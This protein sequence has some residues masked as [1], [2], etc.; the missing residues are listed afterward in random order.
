M[1]IEKLKFNS[2]GKTLDGTSYCSEVETIGENIL[3]D[4]EEEATLIYPG[5]GKWAS[6]RSSAYKIVDD[7]LIMMLPFPIYKIKHIYVNIKDAVL[8]MGSSLY[9]V[10]DFYNEK[11]QTLNEVDIQKFVLEEKEWAALTIEELQIVVKAGIYKNNTFFYKRGEKEINVVTKGYYSGFLQFDTPVYESLIMSAIAIQGKGYVNKDGRDL[12]AG[13][14]G[15]HDLNQESTLL[16]E[17]FRFRVEYVP[18]SSA[19]KMKAHK[20]AP[21][22]RK[23]TQI[24]NQRAEVNS[25]TA[26]GKMLYTQAQK[27]GTER[28]TIVKTHK[29]LAEIPPKGAVVWHE[30]KKYRLVAK[31]YE[32]TNCVNIKVT[33]TLSANWSDKS[34][35]IA[36]DQKY[37]NYAIP[38]NSYVWRTI[39][40]EE[41]IEVGGNEPDARS[42]LFT[43]TAQ[44]D[45]KDVFA[46]ESAN[47]SVNNLFF[48]KGKPT[49]QGGVVLNGDGVVTSVITQGI[50]KSMIFSATMQDNL[51]AGMRIS[52]DNTQYCE[53]VYYCEENG[54][55]DKCTVLLSNSIDGYDANAFPAAVNKTNYTLLPLY[56]AVFEL[57]KDPAEAIKV[58]IQVHFIPTSEWVV[59][60]NK[61]AQ[62]NPLV[63]NKKRKFR[64]WRLQNKLRD[65]A[66]YLTPASGDT[67][68]DITDDAARASFFNTTGSVTGWSLTVK[69]DTSLAVAWAI[70]DENNELYIGSND[71]TKKKVFFAFQRNKKY[72]G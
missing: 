12:A 29:K 10:K 61:I 5:E 24:I 3:E 70:T 39:Y 33:Y 46:C 26:F 19:T 66:D 22:T 68:E 38:F 27:M 16:N 25:A 62:N 7:A 58:T 18:L 17:K 52:A 14:Q 30:G 64:F 35:H 44:L 8:S 36:V 2:Y 43:E 41:F 49:Q 21:T 40:Y 60:G 50:G 37:R 63:V 67:Y 53:E 9:N 57:D 4:S 45:T 28:I 20:A 32:M 13:T 31:H 42:S 59:L 11:G 23:Y 51:S 48:Y 65:G 15:L 54:K 55:L 71:A 1:S 47:V 56:N 6:A 34:N 72:G 69:A